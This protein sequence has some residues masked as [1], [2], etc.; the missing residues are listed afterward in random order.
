MG[1][2]HVSWELGYNGKPPEKWT[3]HIGK[4]KVKTNKDLMWQ[5]RLCETP[6]VVEVIA[7]FKESKDAIAFM[8][9]ISQ[10]KGH[11]VIPER[12]V[13]GIGMSGKSYSIEHN[14]STE[15]KELF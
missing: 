6:G 5:I 8:T 15:Y 3:Y 4:T 9:I 2:E 10:N 12:P 1:I 11:N 13:T 7:A 14:S